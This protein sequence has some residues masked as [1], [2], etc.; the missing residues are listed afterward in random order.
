MCEVVG[1][2]GDLEFDES[3]PDGSP[4]KL[5]N[6][7]RLTDLGWTAETSL[8]N[9]LQETYKWFLQSLIN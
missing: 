6:V 7:D 8:K 5:L 4:R 1:F 2:K 3:M 9:G